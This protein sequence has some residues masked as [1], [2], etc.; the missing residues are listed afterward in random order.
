MN[1][2]SA[3]D[4]LREAGDVVRD[5]FY[6]RDEE[7]HFEVAVV[8]VSSWWIW[9]EIIGTSL[10]NL[11]SRFGMTLIEFPD[12]ARFSSLGGCGGG[13]TVDVRF[14]LVNAQPCLG[15]HVGMFCL[16]AFLHRAART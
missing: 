4:V 12:L 14:S 8:V 10:L 15:D 7:I 2:I 13:C 16:V 6:E 11:V 1:L 9:V 5:G 3:V